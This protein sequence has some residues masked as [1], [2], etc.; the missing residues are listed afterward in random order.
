MR[1][2]C[3]FRFAL[4]SLAVLAVILTAGCSGDSQMMEETAMPNTVSSMDGYSVQEKGP[5]DNLVRHWNPRTFQA[6]GN[7]SL[8]FQLY[9]PDHYQT[10]TS[11]PLILYMHSAGVKCDD[12]SH[13]YKKEARFLRNLEKSCYRDNVIVVAPCCPV[14]EKWV[15]AGTWNQITYDYVHTEPTKYMKAVAELL[16]VTKTQLSIDENRLYLYGMS[17]GGFAVWDLLARHPETFAAAV[18]V[19]GAGDPETAADFS[20]TA[21]W[22]FH[23]EEDRTV[24]KKS[25]DR[26]YQTLREAGRE[27]IRYTVLKGQ[28]HG[29]WDAAGNAEGL[30][31]WLF[32]QRRTP[33]S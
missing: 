4:H 5:F 16:E 10:G 17:M 33:A 3:I 31:D 14:G 22:I 8:P 28:G 1:P 19:A 25:A 18:P 24:P 11:Y 29:I 15:P 21:I 6:S 32:A 30:L 13:I 23:G 20:H 2:V 26:M 9:M 27:D 12:N 7:I